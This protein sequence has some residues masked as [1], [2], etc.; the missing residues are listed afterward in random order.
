LSESRIEVA[1]RRAAGAKRIAVAAAVA[2]FLGLVPLVRADQPG[3]ATT[4]SV[5]F[6][7]PS[8]AQSGGSAAQVQTSVS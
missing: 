2:G 3:H 5:D 7:S 8:I 1:R 6:G 4:S